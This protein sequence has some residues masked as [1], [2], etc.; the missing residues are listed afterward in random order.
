[1]FPSIPSLR[2]RVRRRSRL[3]VE[4]LES[5]ETPA[6]NID[7]S[8]VGKMLIITG[9]D[10]DNEVNI[11]AI[12]G[13]GGIN[14]TLGSTV[15]VTGL[16]DTKIDDGDVAKTFT[17][18]QSIKVVMGDGNDLVESNTDFFLVGAVNIDLGD[19]ENTLNLMPTADRLIGGRLTVK[20]GDG[21]DN[22]NIRGVGADPSQQGFDGM[23]FKLGDGGTSIDLRNFNNFGKVQ[24][25]A[26]EGSDFVQL[27]NMDLIVPGTGERPA[28]PL[29]MNMGAGVVDVFLGGTRTGAT[30][31]AAESVWLGATGVEMGS[32]SLTAVKHGHAG[33]SFDGSSEVNGNLTLKG[34]SV[35]LEARD[36]LNVDG[37]VSLT[38][39]KD[40]EFQSSD[41]MDIAGA[42]TVR[43]T[44]GAASFLASGVGMNVGGSWTVSGAQH[45]DAEWLTSGPSEIS[46]P[47][48]V[49]G[50][51]GEDRFASNA[52]FKTVKGLS[53]NLGGGGNSVTLVGNGTEETVGGK[54]SITTGSGSDSITLSQVKVNGPTSISTGSGGD[55]VDI[56]SGSTLVGATTIDLGS[57]ADVLN[58]G[59]AGTGGPVTFTGKLTARLGAGSDSLALGRAGIALDGEVVFSAAGNVIDGGAGHD[60][61]DDEAGQFDATAVTDSSF[62]DPTP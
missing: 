58:I 16:N 37:K 15:I 56:Y 11:R 20:A 29:S 44:G 19:G 59:T 53:I 8:Q 46:G 38:A 10:L 48:S 28:A 21:G 9:D 33:A 4:S 13:L 26:G 55:S 27:N 42:L 43:S 35:R 40:A 14:S 7:I 60:L 23:S 1:M 30:T 22:I 25:S 32:T 17:G 62:D 57:G 36:E 50:G 61:F 5:R 34:N 51:S 49:I 54:L 31:I 52:N 18:V 47:A 2:R 12:S 6:G 3:N 24:I 39:S 41:A 45:V